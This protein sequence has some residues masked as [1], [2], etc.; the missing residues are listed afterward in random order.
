MPC[1]T[2]SKYCIKILIRPFVE[3]CRLL[4]SLQ[5][6]M[7]VLRVDEYASFFRKG[8]QNFRTTSDEREPS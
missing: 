3:S 7:L 8:C 1:K 2:H 4:A 6:N 5:R